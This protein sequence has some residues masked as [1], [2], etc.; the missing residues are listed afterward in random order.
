MSL[1]SEVYDDQ[2]VPDNDDCFLSPADLRLPRTESV[3]LIIIIIMRINSI[4]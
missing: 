3:S 2:I 1:E 4:T